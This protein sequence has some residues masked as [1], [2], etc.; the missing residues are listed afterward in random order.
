MNNGIASH[1]CYPLTCMYRAAL[2][3]AEGVRSVAGR[4]STTSTTRS[5]RA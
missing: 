3:G 1:L 5:F 4:L 2:P